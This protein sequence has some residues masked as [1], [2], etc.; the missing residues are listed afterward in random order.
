[1]YYLKHTYK[2]RYPPSFL[3]QSLERSVKLSAPLWCTFPNTSFR[4]NL[5]LSVRGRNR[6]KICFARFTNWRWCRCVCYFLWPASSP[7]NYR[8]SRLV[9]Q[10]FLFVFPVGDQAE[11][12]RIPYCL[13]RFRDLKY[14]YRNHKLTKPYLRTWT[15]QLLLEY[16]RRSVCALFAYSITGRERPACSLFYPWSVL[17]WWNFAFPAILSD[18]R[19]L[20][21]GRMNCAFQE[22]HKVRLV[23]VSFLEVKSVV[24]SR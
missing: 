2:L 14:K 7:T 4:V 23:I 5:P 20:P 10:R 22:I 24:I 15:C 12:A 13:R 1:M 21:V 18:D 19:Q 9:P 17:Q 3:A 16:P 11:T 6:L 8:K